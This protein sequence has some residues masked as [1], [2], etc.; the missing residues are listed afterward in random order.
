MSSILLNIYSNLNDIFD[1]IKLKE[2]IDDD[3]DPDLDFK[4][5]PN[6]KN[7]ISKKIKET[8]ELFNN[9]DTEKT[10]IENILKSY[11]PTN[12]S[13][14]LSLLSNF[15]NE[16]DK[17]ISINILIPLILPSSKNILMINILTELNWFNLSNEERLNYLIPFIENHKKIAHNTA[18]KLLDILAVDTKTEYS[19]FK[20][21]IISI[22]PLL[23]VETR[24][25]FNKQLLFL[26][27]NPSFAITINKSKASSNF[28]NY[29]D[30]IKNNFLNIK[31]FLKN[32]NDD[33]NETDIL[34]TINI[35]FKKYN[36]NNKTVSEQESFIGSIVDYSTKL[37]IRNNIINDI[38][39][40]NSILTTQYIPKP[41]KIQNKKGIKMAKDYG[42]DYDY[43]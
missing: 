17:N 39:K 3:F 5:N 41:E 6:I 2:Y 23:N 12:I 38:I 26:S 9:S 8:A 34:K 29:I 32:E 4:I 30:N 42:D 25:T 36:F 16:I 28:K 7:T 27:E 15:F 10:R 21:Y 37:P 20:E 19:K 1:N 35:V 43:E 22:L 40:T 14:F 31:T 13:N 33:V 18:I 11:V 24:T